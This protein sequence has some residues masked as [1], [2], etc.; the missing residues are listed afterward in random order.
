MNSETF[1]V[2][3]QNVSNCTNE[4]DCITSTT[5]TAEGEFNFR[6]GVYPT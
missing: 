2:I 6:A 5:G 4:K 3:V 1:E